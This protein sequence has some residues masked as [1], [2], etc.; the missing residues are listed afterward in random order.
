MQLSSKTL[1]CTFDIQGYLSSIT[2]SQNSLFNS[3]L[4]GAN[5]VYIMY[6]YV[7]VNKIK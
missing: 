2:V 5:Q 3:C 7:Y 4:N 6:K 1:I